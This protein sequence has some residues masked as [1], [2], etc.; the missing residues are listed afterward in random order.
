[1][2]TYHV[3]C[4]WYNY[5]NLNSSTWEG[6]YSSFEKREQRVAEAIKEE[7]L[8][9]YFPSDE[10]ADPEVV[11]E[12]E[13]KEYSALLA[14]FMAGEWTAFIEDAIDFLDEHDQDLEVCRWER[15][16][17]LTRE[18]SE[19]YGLLREHGLTPAEAKEMLI[20]AVSGL[21]E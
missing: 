12:E 6:R 10:W 14:Q 9:E 17:D 1:M 21:P 19:E 18:V 20:S 8:D 3:K 13:V 11:D 15:A 16:L 5:V 4:F 7:L 2:E